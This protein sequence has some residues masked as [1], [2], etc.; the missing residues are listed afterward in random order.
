MTRREARA[1]CDS[2]LSELAAHRNRTIIRSASHWQAEIEICKDLARAYDV[3]A[4]TS[5]SPDY[6]R[7]E[8]AKYRRTIAILEARLITIA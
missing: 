2:A 7:G 4:E 1:L 8:A 5:S 3:V 6:E